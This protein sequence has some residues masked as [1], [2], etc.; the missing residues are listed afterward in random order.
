MSDTRNRSISF[1]NQAIPLIPT[2]PIK[3]YRLLCSAVVADPTM[4]V[5]WDTIG[6]S[7]ADL[8]NSSGRLCLQAAISAYRRCLE[9][10]TG[11]TPGDLTPQVRVKAMVNLGHRLVNAGYIEEAETVTREALALLESDV[12]LDQEGHAFAWTNL[13][14]SL[15]M[16]GRHDEAIAYATRAYEMSPEPIIETGLAFALLFG[17]DYESGLRH[18]DAR[19]AYRI[20]QFQ[21]M[22]YDRWNGDRVDTLLVES[23]MGAGDTISFAR[24][25]PAASKSVKKLVFRVQP[26]ILRMMTLALSGLRNVEVV[27]QSPVFPLADAWSPVMGLPTALG[28]TTEQIKNHPQ[29][30]RMPPAR[31]DVPVGWKAPGRKLHV[32]IAYAGN[33]QNDIDVHRTIPVTQ[34]LSLYRVPGVQLYSVQIGEPVKQLHDEGCASLIRDMSPWI[35]DA[36]DTVAILREMDLVISCESFVAHLAAAADL[37]CWVP[38][39]V[40]GGDWRIGRSGDHPL[41]YP[42]TLVFRQERDGD[43]TGTFGK[44]VEAL[45]ERSRK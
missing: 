11:E 15:S 26:D 3:A 4:A 2:D 16:Q 1:H 31:S 40:Y 9:L 29:V 41:W 28:L 30:W 7:L 25:I 35:K 6:N 38:V 8:K 5:G 34:F 20:P 42:N 19:I 45:R 33:P 14:L 10:P 27:P 17:G 39:W 36:L 18:F 13:S 37:A 43:W 44:M 22:P 12:S 21:A 24:F 23:D 32:A